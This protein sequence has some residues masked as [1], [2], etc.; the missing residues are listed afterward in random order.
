MGKARMAMWALLVAVAVWASWVAVGMV[1]SQQRTVHLV[2][3]LYVGKPVE[4]GAY[5]VLGPPSISASFIDR[6]LSAYHSP[7]A[8]LG[9]MIES[10]G[11]RYGIDPV[12]ALAFFWHESGFGTTG[13]ARVTFSPGNERC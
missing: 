11:V 8:G 10:Q 5:S 2:A 13:E 6:V 3:V 9:P 12:Y 7:A 1:H 4:T